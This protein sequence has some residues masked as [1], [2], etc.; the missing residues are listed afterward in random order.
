[1]AK[2][3]L[4]AGQ[5]PTYSFV[6][7]GVANY[8]GPADPVWASWPLARRQAA[9]RALLA[10][11][12]YGP[13]HPLTVEIKST[14][15]LDAQHLMTSIQADWQLIGVKAT[16][17]QEETQ[18]A[19]QDWHQRDFEAGFAA[20]IADYDDPLSF[21]Y[22]MQSKTGQQ[23]YGDY[24]SPTYDAL[25]HTADLEPDGAKRAAILRQAEAL[26][27]KDQAITPIYVSL[28]RNLVNPRVS[29]WVDNIIDVHR[30]QYLCMKGAA[31][32]A[33]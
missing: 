28:N 25:L 14:D 1:M 16:L 15:Q 17:I 27:L 3:L 5:T 24:N 7:P 12:G 21:L 20:W 22:L 32:A 30:T 4:R 11:A 13:N 31:T 2:Q 6:P 23:N 18:I 26:M 9:A 33:R 8:V 10:Q 29:G 19:F